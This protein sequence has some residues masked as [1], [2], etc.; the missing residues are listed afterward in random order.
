MDQMKKAM[1]EMKDSKRKAN[2]VDDLVHK[3]NY[4]FITSITSRPLPSKFK[5]PTLESYDGTR[6][7]CDHITT[8]KMTMHL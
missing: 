8:F 4:P 1:E 7:P 2:H 3:T 6:D 5:M